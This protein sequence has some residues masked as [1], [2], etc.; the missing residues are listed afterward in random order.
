MGTA[1]R[2]WR[3]QGWHTQCKEVADKQQGIQSRKDGF[4]YTLGQAW[5]DSEEGSRLDIQEGWE[6]QGPETLCDGL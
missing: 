4:F 3:A 1:R 2:T 6:R 5:W